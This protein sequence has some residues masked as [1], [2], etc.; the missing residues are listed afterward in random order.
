MGR[1]RYTPE[2]IVTLLREAE[3]LLSKGATVGAACREL[4]ISE[5]TY[6]RWRREYGGQPLRLLTVIDE[7]SRSSSSL[8]V[9]GRTATTSRSMGSSGTNF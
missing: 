9:R 1:K 8:G 7:Y 2:Q 3:V 6:Y 5:H 4:G